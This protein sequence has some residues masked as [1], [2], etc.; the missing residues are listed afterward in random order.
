SVDNKATLRVFAEREGYDF[1]LLA[2][3][4]PHGEV[5]RAY[6]VFNETTGTAERG[7]VLI[8]TEGMVRVSFATE[9]GQARGLVAYREVLAALAAWAR[10]IPRSIRR[11]RMGAFSSVGR[12]LRL[13]RRCRR[14]E[15]G[16]AHRMTIVTKGLSLLSFGHEADLLH[17]AGG[18]GDVRRSAR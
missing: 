14:F 2:D 16:R 7:T 4:W 12:A 5:A 13:H 9:R 11:V 17:R 10:A 15:P 18:N 3:F 6:G 1:E 8:D